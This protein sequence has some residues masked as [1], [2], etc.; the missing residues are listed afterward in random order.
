VIDGWGISEESHGNA[1]LNAN[2]PVMDKL[3]SGNWQQIEAHGLHVGVPEGQ[4]GNSEVG[5]QNIGA[6]RVIYQD[7]VR[8]NSAVKNNTLVENEQLKVAAKR[9]VD[10]NGRLHLLGLVS[11]GGVHSHIDHLFGLVKAAKQL[12]VPH[13]YVHFFGDGRDTS[14]TS[15]AGFLESTLAFF[16]F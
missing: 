6:G 14:P 4:M 16:F 9:A 7:I 1:I 8:I 2:T 15:G 10:G 3:C 11:D 12:K 5:H 13:L